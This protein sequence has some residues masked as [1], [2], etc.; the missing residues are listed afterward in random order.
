MKFAVRFRIDNRW[1]AVSI[2]SLRDVCVS[3][4]NRFSLKESEI[5]TI[6]S[7]RDGETFQMADLMLTR[8]PDAR[9]KETK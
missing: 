4:V 1:G 5:C 7:L 8:R 9:Q 3:L 2:Y 6:V